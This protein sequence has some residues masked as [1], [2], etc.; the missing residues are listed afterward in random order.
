MG[1]TVVTRTSVLSSL[2]NP[3]DMQW[4]SWTTLTEELNSKQN[5]VAE[6]IMYSSTTFSINVLTYYFT[7]AR[8]GV[9]VGRTN[10]RR[11]NIRIRVHPPKTKNGS[12]NPPAYKEEKVT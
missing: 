8:I 11:N 6:C 3:R 12:L 2:K 7:S 4:Q 10:T 5:T 1:L 9:P